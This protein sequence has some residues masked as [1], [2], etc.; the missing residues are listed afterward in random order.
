MVVM[1]LSVQ[2]AAQDLKRQI[3]RHAAKVLKAKAEQ[4]QL[5][6][7]EIVGPKNQTLSFVELMQ[8]IFLSRSGE[9]VV[10]AKRQDVD[11]V[12][13]VV[14][15]EHPWDDLHRDQNPKDDERDPQLRRE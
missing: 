5:S 13:V 15:D 11:E 4:L 6:A 14:N 7:G 9:L 10:L 3:L 1:G 12:V 8:K 2:R